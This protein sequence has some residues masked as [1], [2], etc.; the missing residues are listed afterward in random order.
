VSN[1][2]PLQKS[3]EMLEKQNKYL[4]DQLQQSEKECSKLNDEVSAFRDAAAI[5]DVTRDECGRK[6]E[7]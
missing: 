4:Q 5:Y 1:D 7:R 6:R 3:V 2:N